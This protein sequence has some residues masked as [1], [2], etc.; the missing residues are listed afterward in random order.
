MNIIH[1][2]RIIEALLAVLIFEG[3]GILAILSYKK[4]R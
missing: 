3:L 1:E 2:L 4:A